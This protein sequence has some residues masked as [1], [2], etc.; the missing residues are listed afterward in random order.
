MTTHKKLLKQVLAANPKRANDALVLGD[1][2]MR[3]GDYNS[4]LDALQPARSARIP[5]PALNC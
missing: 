3:A 5:M 4:A 1:I 2:Y